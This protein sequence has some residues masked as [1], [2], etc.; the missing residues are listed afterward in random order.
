MLPLPK[1]EENRVRAED[2]LKAIGFSEDS[3]MH[4]LVLI[5][6]VCVSLFQFNCTIF[7]GLG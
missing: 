7:T 4:S 6:E 2:P 1:E 5:S 3:H